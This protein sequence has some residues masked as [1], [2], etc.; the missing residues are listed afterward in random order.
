[1][2]GA[3]ILIVIMVGGVY[4]FVNLV[5]LGEAHRFLM[6]SRPEA[7]RLTQK[8]Q[9]SWPS[10]QLVK[11]F[12]SLPEDWRPAGVDILSIVKA[13]DLKHGRESLD[14]HFCE[15]VYGK[16]GWK[17]YGDKDHQFCRH[18]TYHCIGNDHLALHEEFEDL[19]VSLAKQ[20]ARIRNIAIAGDMDALAALRERMAEYRNIIDETNTNEENGKMLPGGHLPF[21]S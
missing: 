14:R 11:E 20:E 15:W 18:R 2:I 4:G 19:K 12:N 10:R 5:T 16:Y 17:T 1:M 6:R 7:L 9:L 21:I 13:L 8:A 3:L